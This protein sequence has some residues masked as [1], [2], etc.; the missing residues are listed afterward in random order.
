M[1]RIAITG[2]VAE[3]KST[4]VGY[5]AESGLK[6]ESSDRI[7]GEVFEQAEVQ[8]EL[9][10]LLGI[11]APV[12][13]E[14]VRIAIAG[15]PGVRRAVNALMHPRIRERMR[16]S[17]ASV[18]EVPLLYEAVLQGEYDR[19]WVVTCGPQEQ[20]RRLVARLGDEG[21][22]RRLQAT[23]LGSRVKCAIC[24]RIIRTNLPPPAVRDL[25]LEAMK[26]D[27]SW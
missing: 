13:K 18:F 9:A 17:E 21:I 27:A 1:R 16:A 22:A 2:G 7:A 3:G 26:V 19:V 14:S 20:L 6:V 4:V 23:Q 5:L 8:A 10:R 24:D 12:T 25:V 11:P 15:H